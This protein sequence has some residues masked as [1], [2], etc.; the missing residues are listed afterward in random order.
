MPITFSQLGKLG[1][2]GNA[3]F[4][5]A[6]TIALALRNNDTY[7]LPHC[8]LMYTT[9]IPVDKFS[10]NIKFSSVY[11][12]P[13]FHYA[14][15]DY[16]PNLSLN[17]YYQS[18]LYFDD[19]KNEITNL[20]TPNDNL[21]EQRNKVSIHIRRTDYLTFK[22]CYHQ[23]DR[24]NYYDKAMEVSGGT[25]FLI[26]SDDIRW[27]KD[28]FKGNEFE[29]SE[30]NPGHI[31]MKYMSLCSDNIIA[32]SSFSYWSAYLNRNPAKI[33]IAPDKWFG[34]ELASTHN[35]KDLYLPEMI[36]I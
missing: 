7:I 32:N 35:T 15:I 18:S 1:R 9:N 20:F 11:Q 33:I 19:Y 5:A 34:P 26:F 13:H 22:N 30:G 10:N 36:R 8:E 17:G 31:D 3:L 28:N 14:P 21:P 29:F 27:A 4:Q 2:R 12:E 6:T 23:L 25:K 16:K 24:N